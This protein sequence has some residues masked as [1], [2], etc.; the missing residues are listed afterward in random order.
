MINYFY[1]FNGSPI[2][3]INLKVKKKI[4]SLEMMNKLEN[5][6]RIGKL[7]SGKGKSDKIT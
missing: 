2:N 6:V 5:L 4:N 7:D 3:N 1:G